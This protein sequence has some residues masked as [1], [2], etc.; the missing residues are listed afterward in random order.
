MDLNECD[1]NG[2]KIRIRRINNAPKLHHAITNII[3]DDS[4]FKR[5]SNK[6]KCVEK[7]KK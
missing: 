6:S 2:N 7:N 5:Y 4:N 3:T 1:D